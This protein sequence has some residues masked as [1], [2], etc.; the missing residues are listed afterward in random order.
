MDRLGVSD[1]DSSKSNES[2]A[3]SYIDISNANPL[4]AFAGAAG[5]ACISIVAWKLLNATVQFSVSHPVDDQIYVVQ[6]L[7]V[8]VRTTLVC[9]FA[10]GSGISGVTALGLALLGVRTSYGI[11]TGEFSK[12]DNP[13]SDEKRKL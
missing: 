10:L 7:A 11:V 4:S 12:N 6:R 9:L 8:V 1:N 2:A 3:P 5:A 13:S